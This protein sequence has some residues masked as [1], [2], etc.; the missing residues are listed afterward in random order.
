MQ[1]SNFKLED[2]LKCN[3]EYKDFFCD[4]IN[5]EKEKI[6]KDM[7]IEKKELLKK[8][9]RFFD[10]DVDCFKNENLQGFKYKLEQ[11]QPNNDDFKLLEKT[12]KYKD[13]QKTKLVNSSK[14]ISLNGQ[15]GPKALKIYRVNSNNNTQ[16]SDCSKVL[17]LHGTKAPNVEGILKMGFKPSKR[18]SWGP[19]VY[20]TDSFSYAKNY[21]TFS[22]VQ[23]S[24]VVKKVSYIF[25]NEVEKFEGQTTLAHS[26]QQ[27][28]EQYLKNSP[29]VKA[30]NDVAVKLKLGK[31]IAKLEKSFDDVFDSKE[32]KISQGTFVRE[33]LSNKIVLAHHSLVVPAYLLEIEE[34]FSL[35]SHVDQI[36]YSYFGLIDCQKKNLNKIVDLNRNQKSSKNQISLNKG[37]AFT[38]EAVKTALKQEI[39]ANLQEK[40]IFSISQLDAKVNT[41]I[42]QLLFDFNLLTKTANGLPMYEVKNY[43]CLKYKPE[44][45]NENDS[46]YD[47][48]LQSLGKEKCLQSNI[49]VL[50]MFKINP[51]DGNELAKLRG[52]YLFFK[53]TSSDKVIST[54][55]Q[56]YY[57]DPSI[58]LRKLIDPYQTGMN[59]VITRDELGDNEDEYNA[60]T[61]LEDQISKGLSYYGGADK[62]VK[63][64]SCIF[65]VSSGKASENP[66][67]DAEVL[68]DTRGSHVDTHLIRSDKY[69]WEKPC[70][71]PAY[72]VVLELNEQVVEDSCWTRC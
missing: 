4:Y 67:F 70:K 51:V 63:K 66:F 56:G 60:S 68:T 22:F 9:D 11:L 8:A 10:Y 50:H 40:L 27:T 65:L 61:R 37:S 38:L 12:I 46:D 1:T 20:M 25:V 57:K 13:T 49:K 3:P 23:A 2:F 59:S 30:F 29:C 17:L 41:I 6:C 34:I 48:V 42:D 32:R 55:T 54:L 31:K 33:S 18:G 19:G 58:L 44:L 36:V 7:K 39:N 14:L 21:G 69:K 24:G 35:K 16:V 53:G 5:E 15:E 45:L 64:I 71:V 47:F 26:K 43:Q 52:E 72:L 62:T 28:Y